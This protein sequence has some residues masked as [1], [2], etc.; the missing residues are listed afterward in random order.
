M[1]VLAQ[2]LVGTGL[3]WPVP[4]AEDRGGK[5]HST[6]RA[7]CEQ[8]KSRWT[9]MASDSSR[10]QYEIGEANNPKQVNWES[11]PPFADILRRA[12]SDRLI[13]SLDHPLLNKLRGKIE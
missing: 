8:G 9:I 6:E 10:G 7:A 5:W 2:T 11:F 4:L 12:Y 1:L 3:A 13:D